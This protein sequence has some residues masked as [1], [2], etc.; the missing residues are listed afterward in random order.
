MSLCISRLLL[1]ATALLVSLGAVACGGAG[2]SVP[3]GKIG[4]VAAENEY[5][6]VAQQIGGRYV[7][8]QSVENNPNTDPHDYEISPA[9]AEEVSSAQVLIENGVGYDSW[10]SRVATAS[11]SSARQ[12]INAQDLLHLPITTP[13]PHLWYSPKTMPVVAAAIGRAFAKL[14]PGHA[15]YFEADV[16]KFDASLKLWL[17]AIASFKSKYPG[18]S[19][20]TTEPVA[21]YLLQAMGIDNRTP[22]SL[23]ADIMNGVDPSAQ[24]ISS[25]DGLFSAHRVT[26]F[27]HNEQVTDPLTEIFVADAQRAGIPVVGVYETMPTP[28]FTYQSWMLAEVEAIEK[29]VVNKISTATL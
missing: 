23:Q 27:V 13:N 29:A 5:G 26:V 9:I 24:G 8:V 20:A 15:A 14:Q 1:A 7:Y 19:V 17:Q 6:N 10:M 2:G 21:D 25:Q 28:G 16:A 3:A 11:P 12:M 18:T 4:V 22:F